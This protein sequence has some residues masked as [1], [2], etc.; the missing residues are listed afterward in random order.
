VKACIAILF[1]ITL[2]AC[3]EYRE[4]KVEPNIYPANYRSKL[5][6]ILRDHLDDPTN[7]RDAF[8]AEPVLKAEAGVHRYVVCV[9]FNSKNKNGQYEG[10][11]DFAAFYY[12]GEFTQ[13]VKASRELCGNAPYQSF[14]ELQKL[15][16]SLDCKS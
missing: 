3:G 13:L 7:I 11:R 4:P 12:A 8:V 14:P 5:L 1:A 10:S 6:D 15:C 16:R 9:R 2:G